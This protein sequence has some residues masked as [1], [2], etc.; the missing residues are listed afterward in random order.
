MYAQNQHHVRSEST[1]CTLKISIMYAQNQKNGNVTTLTEL[2]ASK[3]N[4]MSK[5]DSQNQ[6]W[7]TINTFD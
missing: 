1:S 3:L 6:L 2:E 4:K 5:I 7:S